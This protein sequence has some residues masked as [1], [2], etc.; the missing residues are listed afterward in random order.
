MPIER[1]GGNKSDLTL[2]SA[3]TKLE[4]L[5]TGDED[6]GYELAKP[7]RKEP[8][9]ADSP[10][11]PT[12]DPGE[13]EPEKRD[14]TETTKGE[15]TPDESD[16]G[17]TDEPE[18]GTEQAAEPEPKPRYRVK[19]EGKWLEV[20]EEELVNGYSRTADYTRKT[21]AL[22]E[23]RR[24]A[25]TE[26]AAVREQRQKSAALLETLS[27]AI[28]AQAAREPNWE[29]EAKLRPEQLPARLAQWQEYRKNV[30]TIENAKR[31]AA[32]EVAKD[33]QA[34][35]RETVA[36]EAAKLV[37]AIP[38]WKDP[39]VAKTEKAE[40][41]AYALSLGYTQD[42]LNSIT[43][44]KLILVLRDAHETARARS[45]RPGVE[46][47]LERVMSVRSATPGGGT[48]PKQTSAGDKARQRAARTGRVE[49]AAAAI[50]HMD[51]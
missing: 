48:P 6:A 47:R 27:E 21:Q 45:K 43:D 22:A 37:D 35:L 20:D 40:L 10:P 28:K 14:A 39:E 36:Q 16:A 9:S 3:R 46:K 19:V 23:D 33:Y 7:Q 31:L 34:K 50:G 11:P 25:E 1:E 42:Q 26:L 5:L 8:P 30:E 2:D 12:T 32:E 13:S 44:H 51:L 38:E 41:N 29:E 17:K 24:A 18:K 49:D 15:E 4:S